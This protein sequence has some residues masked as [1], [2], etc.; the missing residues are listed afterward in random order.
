[1]CVFASKHVCRRSGTG[2]KSSMR[3]VFIHRSCDFFSLAFLLPNEPL[4]PSDGEREKDVSS[5]VHAELPCVESEHNGV[6]QCAGI[7]AANPGRLASLGQVE[8]T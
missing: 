4:T 5:A 2:L 8:A 7:T 6:L 3:N 1:M